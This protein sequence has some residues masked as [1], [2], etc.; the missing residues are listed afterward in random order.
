MVI[1][2]IG[3]DT[4]DATIDLVEG[5][6]VIDMLGLTTINGETRERWG[7]DYSGLNAADAAERSRS[8]AGAELARPDE[9][10]AK[11]ESGQ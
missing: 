11:L 6:L 10:I 7:P 9:S 3:L 2:D 5:S 4:S 1:A 8:R